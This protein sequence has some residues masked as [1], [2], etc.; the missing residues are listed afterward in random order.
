MRR[1]PSIRRSLAQGNTSLA[2]SNRFPRRLDGRRVT[3]AFWGLF[4]VNCTLYRFS[5]PRWETERGL[6]DPLGADQSVQWISHRPNNDSLPLWFRQAV[7]M[8]LGHY[9]SAD[10][11]LILH[12]SNIIF[13]VSDT[14]TTS[15]ALQPP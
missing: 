8:R 4:S 10:L 6:N 9:P 15:H 14:G 13:P 5:R 1:E 11:S 7:N 3:A 12:L 2:V